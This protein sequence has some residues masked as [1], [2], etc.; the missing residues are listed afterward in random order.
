MNEIKLRNILNYLEMYKNIDTII[1][2]GGNSKNGPEY[3]LRQI[4]KTNNIKFIEISNEIPKVHKFIFDN[5]VIKT[6]SL[7]S[8]SNTANR[9]IGSNEYYKKRKK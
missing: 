8:L 7:T 1:F 2:T 4:L 9:F 6:I 3:F 5:R